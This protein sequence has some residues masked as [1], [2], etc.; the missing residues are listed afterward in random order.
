M[1][2]AYKILVKNFSYRTYNFQS[3]NSEQ[4][5][6]RE[7]SLIPQT[8]ATSRSNDSY[9]EPSEARDDESCGPHNQM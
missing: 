9:R 3:A 8:S 7:L 6:S 5:L 1:R 4:P 2:N